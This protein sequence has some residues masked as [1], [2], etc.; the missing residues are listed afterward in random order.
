MLSKSLLLVDGSQVL[1]DITR[2]ILERAGYSVRCASGA[3]G[4]REMLNDFVPDGIVLDN[5]LPDE[6]GLEFCRE[7]RKIHKTPVL[8]LSNNKEDE[9]PALQAGSNDFLKKPFDYEIF[10]ARISVLLNIRISSPPDTDNNEGPEN[11]DAGDM[12]N[13]V[14]IPVVR[15]PPADKTKRAVGKR[16]PYM[17]AAAF[18]VVAIILIGI[19]ISLRSNLNLTDIPE[20]GIPLTDIPEGFEGAGAVPGE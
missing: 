19:F 4:A 3:A 5:E 2:K 10:K 13:Q 12:A 8:F 9:L 6:S 18:L 7:L 20:D 11:G 17:V 15:P 1:M 14:V 16:L